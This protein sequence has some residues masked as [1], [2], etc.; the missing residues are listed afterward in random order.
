MNNHTITQ[1]QS[2]V[3]NDQQNKYQA[4]TIRDITERP[5]PEPIPIIDDGILTFDSQACIVGKPK[6]GK[7]TFAIHLGLRLA[8]G[9]ACLGLQILRVCK[10]LYLNFEIHEA[11]MERR[12]KNMCGEESLSL[13]CLISSI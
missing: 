3:A 4:R 8:Q 1:A 2:Q 6:V 13:M 11:M 9:G 7:S 5:T 10:V 12:I